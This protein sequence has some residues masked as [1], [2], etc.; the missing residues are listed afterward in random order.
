IYQ[1][2]PTE[3]Y[4]YYYAHLDRYAEGIQEGRQLKRG[5]LIGYVGVTGNSDP[6]A[7]HLHLAILQLGPTKEWWHDTTPINPYGVFMSALAAGQR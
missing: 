1:Y 5:D 2:D 7:P 3:T 4:T 6:T